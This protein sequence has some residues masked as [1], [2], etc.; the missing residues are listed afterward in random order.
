MIIR[1]L[2]ANHDWTF[3]SGL[4]NYIG[5]NDG[6]GLNINTRLLSWLNDCFFDMGAGIDWLNLL[7]SLGQQ[8]M[9]NMNIRRV[10]L[11]SFGVTGITAFNTHLD[12]QTRRFTANYTINTIYSQ[13]YQN[14]LIQDIQNAR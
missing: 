2:D 8:N 13:G 12:P 10:I 1:N 4:A 11:Q 9:L 6:I 5:G 3:G 14:S 7:G